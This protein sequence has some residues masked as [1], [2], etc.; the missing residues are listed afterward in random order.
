[1]LCDHPDMF[2]GQLSKYFFVYPIEAA[3]RS[4]VINYRLISFTSA[5]CKQLEHIITG[6]LMQAWVKSDWL[7]RGEHGF[8][9]EYSSE[10]QLITVC[11]GI[12]DSFDESVGIDAII[13]DF[14]KVFDFVPRD[15]LLMNLAFS[16]VDSRLVSWVREFL[17]GRTDMVSVGGQLSKEVKV[18]SASRERFCPRLSLLYVNDIWRNIDS[19]IRLFADNCII[20][21]KITNKKTERSCKKF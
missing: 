10:I 5:V 8:R 2:I 15:R 11:E 13:I 16:G 21:R 17:V 4:A 19:S 20:Y 18:T 12:S 7:Y 14:S 9:L 1:M 3:D 6:Y